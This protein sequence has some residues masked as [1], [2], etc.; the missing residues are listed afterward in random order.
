[1]QG[2]GAV[3][4]IWLTRCVEFARQ[5]AQ[6]RKHLR[7]PEVEEYVVALVSNTGVHG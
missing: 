3:M 6:F 1:V 7:L 5:R 4:V 2:G